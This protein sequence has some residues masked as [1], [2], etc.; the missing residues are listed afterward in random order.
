MDCFAAS[1]LE[2]KAFKN[3]I[4]IIAAGG[5]LAKLQIKYKL[6]TNKFQVLGA[7]CKAKHAQR[8]K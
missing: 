6:C 5:N 4:I 1:L 3:C 8:R 7:C 2:N